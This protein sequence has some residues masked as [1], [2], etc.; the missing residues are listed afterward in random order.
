MDFTPKIYRDLLTTFL[1]H[2]WTFQTFEHFLRHPAPKAVILR[3]DI[4]K[5]P[6]NALKMAQLEH[7]LGVTGSGLRYCS[8]WGIISGCDARGVGCGCDGKHHGTGP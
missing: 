4:D 1:G 7:D 5:L 6:A 3:H 8:Y 2:G